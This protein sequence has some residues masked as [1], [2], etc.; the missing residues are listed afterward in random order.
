MTLDRT[1]NYGT[2][3]YDTKGETE[4]TSFGFMYEVGR[5]FAL[6]EDGDVCLQPVA[7]VTFRHSSV[8]GYE[9]S[10]C[11]AT[12]AVDE[13]TYTAVT[14]GVGARLQAVIGTSIYNRA[15]I[16]EA[17]ALAKFDMGDR[18]SEADVRLTQGGNTATVKSAEVGAFGAE[19]GVGV[20]VPMGTNAG[21]IFVDGSAEIRS[22]YTN[23][24]GTVGYR[25]NF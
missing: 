16:L 22:G 19:F 4:G 14:L 11:D 2:G 15:S 9:E 8:D 7:N 20:T 10:G 1:V 25:I 21:S 12:L 6:T 23:I 13:Q 18:E 5:V 3:S 17:R 24:N